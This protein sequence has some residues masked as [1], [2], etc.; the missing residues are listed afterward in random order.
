VATGRKVRSSYVFLYINKIF[1]GLYWNWEN[2]DEQFVKSRFGEEEDT[3][4]FYKCT[5]NNN[6]TWLGNDP[7]TYKSLTGDEDTEPAYEPQNDISNKK[8]IG[9]TKLIEL[10][11][12]LNLSPDTS[13]NETFS[14]SFEYTRYTRNLIAEIATSNYDGYRWGGSNFYVYQSTK[15]SLFNFLSFD[16]DRSFGYPWKNDLSFM[17]F[18][19]PYDWVAEQVDENGKGRPLV[20]RTLNIPALRNQFT[21]DFWKLLDYFKEDGEMMTRAEELSKGLLPFGFVRDYYRGL[22][23]GFTAEDCTN[24]LNE[25]LYRKD[26]SGVSQLQR[27]SINRYLKEK[28]ETLK[29]YLE[30]Y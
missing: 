8:S 3:G 6:F 18:L 26:S 25:D 14:K 10:F 1:R 15:N 7:A 30:T 24:G 21:K 4:V 22:D 17:P 19:N 20:T 9:F 13:F 2:I 28:I 12:A 23:S 16:N 5:G 11:S 27:I 29:K